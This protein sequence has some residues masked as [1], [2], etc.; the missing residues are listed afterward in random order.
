MMFLS[1][2]EQEDYLKKLGKFIVRQ[3][4]LQGLKQY[5][6]SDLLD[7]DVR[8]LRRIEKGET[9]VQ[10]LFLFELSEALK[11]PTES[12]LDLKSSLP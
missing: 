6:L 8:V 10:L 3:R 7:I 12:F 5:E 9:N 2:K 1:K 11:I 4:E